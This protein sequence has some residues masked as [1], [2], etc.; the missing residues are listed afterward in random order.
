MKHEGA[1]FTPL[2]LTRPPLRELA[3]RRGQA[4]ADAPQPLCEM[5]GAEVIASQLKRICVRCGFLGG[6]GREI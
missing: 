3:D 1:P 5:C 6:R 2:P 4:F